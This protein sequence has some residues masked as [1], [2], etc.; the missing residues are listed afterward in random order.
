MPQIKK[1]DTRPFY[2]AM[3]KIDNAGQMDEVKEKMKYFTVDG[4]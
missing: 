1:S 4:K 2:N 3:V